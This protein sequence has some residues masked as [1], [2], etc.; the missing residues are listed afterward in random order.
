MANL[1][2]ITER[3][4]EALRGRA[5]RGLHTEAHLTGTLST[6]GGP[7]GGVWRGAM[8]S[9]PLEMQVLVT[10]RNAPRPGT[11]TWH[12]TGVSQQP[13]ETKQYDTN[14]GPIV[15]KSHSFNPQGHYY[16]LEGF[17]DVSQLSA[18][19]VH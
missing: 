1:T 4:V 9:G 2:D 7:V 6:P 3:L 11:P 14:L 10:L 19:E 15:V 18:A 12:A 8:V 16:E 17:G 5:R 13:W